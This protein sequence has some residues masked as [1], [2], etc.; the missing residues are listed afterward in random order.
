MSHRDRPLLWVGGRALLE[1][2]VM[3]RA[4]A[5]ARTL[6]ASGRY[7]INL[8]ERRDHFLI[9]FCAALLRGHTNLLPASRAADLVEEV[10]ALHSGAYRCEDDWAKQA[11]EASSALRGERA[12]VAPGYFDLPPPEEAASA[13]STA[14]SRLWLKA[15][16]PEHVAAKA[17][18]SGSTGMPQGH[19]KTWRSFA[20]SSAQTACRIR[21]CLEPQYGAAMPWVVA[22]VPPQHMYGLETSIILPL[23]ADVAVHASRPLFPADI[24]AALAEVPE[25]RVLV[26]TPVHMRAIAASGET[27]PRIAL[28]LSSTAPLDAHLA[29]TIEQQ[30]E[31]QVLELFGS[32]ET[33]AIATRRTSRERAWKLFASVMLTPDADGTSVEAPWF[34]APARLQDLIEA[35]PDNRFVILGRSADMIDVAG[36]RASLADITRRLLAIPGVQD[37]VVFQPDAPASGQVRRVA[38]LVVAPSLTA[39][40][41]SEQLARAVDP[42]FVPRPLV[43]VPD[44]PRNEVGKLPRE[45]LLEALHAAARRGA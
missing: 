16:P 14:G 28:V 44:L 35:Q 36:K 3:Q 33:C 11:L 34:D 17:F 22:T 12:G 20:G 40:A 10:A 45:R 31:T 8:C 23:L 26:T 2:E 5:V 27:F 42:A 4:M 43:L 32:T 39:D 1:R 24:A 6:P 21:E 30:L 7:L 37:A 41:I 25:P 29:R 38:A 18:T 15:V 19:I 13:L 9:A